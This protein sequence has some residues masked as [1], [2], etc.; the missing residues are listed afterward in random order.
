MQS[1]KNYSCEELDLQEQLSRFFREDGLGVITSTQ[2]SMSIEDAHALKVM[3]DRAIVIDGHYELPLLWKV[4]NPTL[5][6][7]REMAL[8][9]LNHLKRRLV[10]DKDLYEK[11]DEKI[12]EHQRKGYAKKLSPE[13]ASVTTSKTWYLPHHPVFHPAKPNKV[14]IVFDAAAKCQGTSLNDNLVQGPHL[15]NEV[16]DVLLRFRIGE[17]PIVADIQEMFHQVR[18]S[19]PDRDALRFLWY[20]IGKDE[21]ETYCMNVH[22]FGAKD[23]P[24]IANFSLRK[25]AKDNAAF[26]SEDVV[27]SVEKDFYVDDLLKSFSSDLKAMKFAKDLTDLLLKG[28]FRLTKW[29]SSSKKVLT[30]IPE[31][32][33]ADPSLNLDLDQ[34]P[35]KRALGLHWSV[36]DDT[37]KFSVVK[38]DN[39]ETKRG[40][41]ATIASLYDPLGFATPITL[42]VKA[43]LQ[44]LWQAKLDWDEQLPPNELRKWKEWKEGLPALAQVAIPPCYT[45][46]IQSVMSPADRRFVEEMQLHCFADASAIGYGAVAYIHVAYSDGTVTCAFV[47]GKSRTAPLRKITIP[48]L[49]LQAAVLSIRL[50]ERIQREIEIEFSEVHYWTDSEVVLKYIY[51]DHKRFTVYVGNRVAEIREKSKP[52]QWHYCPSEENPSDDASRGLHPADLTSDCRWLVGPPFLRQPKSQWPL[53]ELKENVEEDPEVLEDLQSNVLLADER[54]LCTLLERYS[55]WNALKSKIVWLTRFKNY[56]KD[57]NYKPTSVFT[58][59]ELKIAE[60]DI[61]RIVQSQAYP[62]EIKDLKE[63]RNVK[64]SSSIAKFNPFIG[65]NGLVRVG[66]RLEFA[67]ISYDA[68]FPAILP[69]HHLV[70]ELL[71]RH[72]HCSNAHIGQEQTLSLLRQVVW[73]CKARSLVRRIVNKCFLCRRINAPQLQ[74]QMAPLP[75]CRVTPYEPPFTFCGIDMF[76]PLLIKQGRSTPKRWG[77]IFTCLTT[78]AV[79][80]EVVPSLDADDFIN[81]LRQFIARR[82]KPK[83]IRT[84]CGTNFRGADNELRASLDS[85]SKGSLDKKLARFE[86]NWIFHPPSAPH[87][88][89]VWERL[90]RETKRALKA[91]LKEALVTEH[92]LRTVFCEVESILNSRPLTKSS[93]DATDPVA[94]TPAHFLL[95]KPA[96]IIPSGNL[97]EIV[98]LTRKRWKQA[99]ILTNHFWSRWIKEYLTTLHLRQKWIRPR[100]DIS[101][102]D[103]VLLHDKRIPRGSWPIAVV[104]KVF[105][106]RDNRIRTVEIKTKDGVLVRP[107]VK[108][109]LLEECED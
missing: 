78:R 58:P 91:V 39:P 4:E 1:S 12:K 43:L 104:T 75:P 37:F 56:L 14:R 96:I 34:L 29:C 70:A 49:E 20:P 72:I 92:V 46:R 6:K 86:L 69:K 9:R 62:E 35:V 19:P 65:E 60:T 68:K 76:G 107:I 109:S 97:N 73:I 82:G 89:G 38:L 13:E 100:R 27:K 80:L 90:V 33:R 87:F 101:V 21:P 106:G 7:N 108:V 63:S 52:D 42:V 64:I 85:W 11:Y 26:F 103:M 41:L 15:T 32:E 74:Q 18:T 36:E 105:P 55:S 5:P 61:L 30:S 77:C 51:N 22:I 88:S 44:R 53:T 48:R 66:S 95:Q 81:V 102:G 83:Q 16:V 17:V 28:G 98:N 25:T 84:D 99:Q 47:L 45:S 50:S 54:R 71:A 67:P 94:I 79:H 59:D 40:V 3:E 93:E 8:K 57:R 31:A 10:N 23:S 24:S 2:K